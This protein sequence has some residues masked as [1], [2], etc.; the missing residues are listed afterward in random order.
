VLRRERAISPSLDGRTVFDDKR[1]K[2]ER[3]PEQLSLWGPHSRE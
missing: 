1:K 3:K 2:V